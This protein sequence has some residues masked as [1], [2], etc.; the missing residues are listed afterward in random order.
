M[1]L[2]APLRPDPTLMPAHS[3]V[4]RVLNLILA[5]LLAAALPAAGLL[6]QAA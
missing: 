3:M 6:A 4:R 5:A 2:V 1:T